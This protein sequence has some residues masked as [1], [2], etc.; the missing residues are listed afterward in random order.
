MVVIAAASERPVKRPRFFPHG[1]D[2]LL[3]NFT[4]LHGDAGGCSQS[5]GDR[6]LGRVRLLTKNPG[7]TVTRTLTPHTLN[8]VVRHTATPKKIPFFLFR[9]T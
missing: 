4:H 8:T 3:E 2:S 9:E 6:G 7:T 5:R 1:N